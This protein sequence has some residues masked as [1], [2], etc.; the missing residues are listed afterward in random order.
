MLRAHYRDNSV[1]YEAKILLLPDTA[2]DKGAWQVEASSSG[3]APGSLAEVS[4]TPDKLQLIIWFALP[5]LDIHTLAMDPPSGVAAE[6]RRRYEGEE[7]NSLIC[8]N[9]EALGDVL[10]EGGDQSEFR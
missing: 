8:I 1:K 2:C 5:V 10:E 6:T 7:E 9:C 4:A 3:R